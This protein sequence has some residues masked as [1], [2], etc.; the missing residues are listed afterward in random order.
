M[1]ERPKDREF[2]GAAVRAKP[3]CI[4]IREGDWIENHESF[5]LRNLTTNYNSKRED[6]EEEDQR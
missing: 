3:T 4:K 1:K 2:L 6:L 5:T